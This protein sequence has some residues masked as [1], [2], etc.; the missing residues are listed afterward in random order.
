M[1]DESGFT[2]GGEVSESEEEQV[3]RWMSERDSLEEGETYQNGYVWFNDDEYTPSIR[4][5]IEDTL[6]DIQ[7][8]IEQSSKRRTQSK[9]Q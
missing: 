3:Y 7:K 5:Y 1:N 9:A 8:S 4:Q 2:S 6:A